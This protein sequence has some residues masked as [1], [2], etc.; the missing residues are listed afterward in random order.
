MAP[1][2]LGFGVALADLIV[3][4]RDDH[5]LLLDHQRIPG[6]NPGPVRILNDATITGSRLGCPAN[7]FVPGFPPG[8]F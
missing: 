6:G 7:W 1:V 2:V 3:V 5:G 4:R 8:A